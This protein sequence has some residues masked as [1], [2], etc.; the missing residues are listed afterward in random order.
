M[1]RF[2]ALIAE[3]P[4]QAMAIRRAILSDG[5]FASVCEDYLSCLAAIEHWQNNSTSQE[6]VAE[7]GQALIEIK[8]EI[9]AYFAKRPGS[10]FPANTE[11]IRTKVIDATAEPPPNMEKN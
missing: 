2:Q 7:Y 3:F 4:D 11:S 1:S 5:D 10:V 8:E 6:R 9:T